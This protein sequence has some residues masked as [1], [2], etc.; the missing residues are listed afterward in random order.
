MRN[1]RTII[2]VWLRET[3]TELSRDV[4]LY[5]YGG[6]STIRTVHD[7]VEVMLHL[8]CGHDMRQL[9][10]LKDATRL[11]WVNCWECE[12]LGKRAG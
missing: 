2:R 5:K 8:S 3:S 10:R 6:S 12:G 11:K 4:T 9:A 7:R 1:Q